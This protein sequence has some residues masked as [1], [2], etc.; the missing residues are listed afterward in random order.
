MLEP[1][2]KYFDNDKEY[3]LENVKS[4]L[5]AW[6]YYTV[7][8]YLSGENPRDLMRDVFLANIERFYNIYVQHCIDHNVVAI[9][10]KEAFEGKEMQ[11]ILE[12]WNDVYSYTEYDPEMELK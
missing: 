7:M 9:P 1:D 8:D 10:R 2:R 11:E 3:Y 6:Y 4:W 5:L 12:R